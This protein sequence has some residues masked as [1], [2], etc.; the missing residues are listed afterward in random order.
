LSKLSH[1]HQ[2]AAND[3]CLGVATIAQTVSK[4]ST[5]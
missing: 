2:P 1:F 4:T 5:D 3:G